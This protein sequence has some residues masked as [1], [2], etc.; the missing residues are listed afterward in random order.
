MSVS[1]LLVFDKSASRV[2]LLGAKQHCIDVK[3]YFVK[4]LKFSRKPITE[5][6]FDVIK[7][8]LTSRNE[9]QEVQ[10]CVQVTKEIYMNC[11]NNQKM[12]KLNKNKNKQI[13]DCVY[14]CGVNI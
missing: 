2:L 6:Q 5:L 8:Y 3:C 14:L 12:R 7:M 9:Q 13:T 1:K 10:F 4:S 11:E